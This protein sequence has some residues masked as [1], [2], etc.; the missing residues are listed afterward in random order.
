MLVVHV[1]FYNWV[2]WVCFGWRGFVVWLGRRGV[3]VLRRRSSI[4]E[5]CSRMTATNRPNHLGTGDGPTV[6][7]M[8]ESCFSPEPYSFPAAGGQGAAQHTAAAAAGKPGPPKCAA[9]AALAACKAPKCV[10]GARP[11]ATS[12]AM[13]EEDLTTHATTAS[14]V[15]DRV[16]C[17]RTCLCI[18]GG[19]F[20]RHPGV[21]K[22]SAPNP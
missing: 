7:I 21:R 10:L 22:P 11:R 20:S 3:F 12:N 2:A 1:L 15:P 17:A 19:P 5:S 9:V 13:S 6:H 14:Q 4:I 18:F 8:D 16:L